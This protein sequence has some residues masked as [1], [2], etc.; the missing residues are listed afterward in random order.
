MTRD[1]PNA[2]GRSAVATWALA[3]AQLVSWGSVY[4]AF[5]LFVVPMEGA[6]GWSRTATN[7][8]LSVGLLVSGLAA[9]PVGTWIDHGH[10][11][12]V[13]VCGTVLASA[14]LAVWS[15][16]HSLVTL[17]VVWIGLGVAMAATLYD[18]VF[19]VITRDFPGSFRKKITLI[20]LVAGFASTVFIPLTQLLVDWL[21]WRGALLALAGFN[22]AICLP[23]H[24]FAIGRDAPR[25]D[26]PD[27][28]ALLKAANAAATRRALRTPTFWALA[29]CFTAYYATFA[30][31]TFHLV[32]LMAE[33]RVSPALILTTMAVIGPA[34]VLARVLWFTVG[35]NVR[36]SI[37]GVVIT[38][39]FPASVVVLM[40]AGTSPALLILFAVLYGGANGMMT[41]LRGTIV[42]EVMWTEGYGAVSGLLSMPSNIAK[43]IAPISA[44]AIWTAGG[45]YVPVE[46][47]VLLVSLVSA[48]AFILAIR[49][50]SG[51]SLASIEPIS[52]ERTAMPIRKTNDA[53]LTEV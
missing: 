31:L 7:A 46:W 40:C 52:N 33:R 30:A 22:L 49:L 26:G 47:T 32:P 23:I 34:Q 25:E 18:P 9:Y 6:M 38:T 27:Y 42:Q 13:M 45:N 43:G 36:G 39:A 53:D 17:F 24:V 3:V 21:Q 12:R 16:A 20:T 19:A 14:M 15:Q 1:T 5:S 37:V 48:V 10:G 44:A 35:R 2:S 28:K 29:V 41:I 11:R 8:A 50:A 4:Y 51:K